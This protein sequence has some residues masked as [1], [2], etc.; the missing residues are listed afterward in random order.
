MAAYHPDEEDK[1]AE[2]I[3]AT[4]ARILKHEDRT[5]ELNLL[6]AAKAKLHYQKFDY[7][8]DHYNL[9]LVVPF[10]VYEQVIDNTDQL[11]PALLQTMNKVAHGDSTEIQVISIIPE[12]DIPEGWREGFVAL[13]KSAFGLPPKHSQY[14]ADIF[15]LMPFSGDTI[16]EAYEDHV[17]KVVKEIGLTINRADNFFTDHGIMDD[18]WGAINAA[19]LVIADCTGRTPNVFYEVGIAHTLGK[20]TI[21]LAQS[22]EDIPFDLRHRRVAVYA[23]TGRGMTQLEAD[24]K[25]AIEGVLSE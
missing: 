1:Y 15:M 11:L 19:R 17:K 5:E 24:L 21:L 3:Q 8:I 23:T 9:D 12:L 25:K 2:K 14:D 6:R 13:S 22:I 4:V 10:D 20:P 16:Q 7:G 18:I